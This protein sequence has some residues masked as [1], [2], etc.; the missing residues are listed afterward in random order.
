MLGVSIVTVVYIAVSVVFLY[1][2][3][4]AG[5]IAANGIRGP[6]RSRLCSAGRGA[7]PFAPIVVVSVAGSLAAVLMASPRVYYAMA[8]DGLFF[9]AL[10]GRLPAGARPPGRSRSRP[11]SPR[12]GVSATFDQILAY[13]MVPT[14]AFL[15]LTVRRSSSSAGGPRGGPGA[16]AIP[17]LPCCSW[18]DRVLIVLMAHERS[19]PCLDRSGRRPAGAARL[20]AG[21]H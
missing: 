1:L 15:A 14:L 10:R 11:C 7:G 17:S 9:P 2:V 18:S 8:R 12:A 6:G 4:P 20:R 3:P 21:F 13:F 5:S 16:R 19:D